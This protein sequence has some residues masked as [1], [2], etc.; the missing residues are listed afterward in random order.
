MKGSAL[1]FRRLSSITGTMSR[2]CTETRL[3]A[4]LDLLTA[5]TRE[6]VSCDRVSFWFW[7]K[8]AG[9]LWTLAASSSGRLMGTVVSALCPLMGEPSF[10]ASCCP[11]SSVRNEE[12]PDAGT[13]FEK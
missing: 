8:P 11:A 1:A 9:R 13:G 10:S 3:P 7:D 6:L 4:V 2:L 5:L 12:K